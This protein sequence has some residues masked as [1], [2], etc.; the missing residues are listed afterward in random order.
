MIIATLLIHD[1]KKIISELIILDDASFKEVKYLTNCESKYSIEYRKILKEWEEK[2]RQL[3]QTQKKNR[4]ISYDMMVKL[5]NIIQGGCVGNV[6][7][8]N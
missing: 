3:E 2:Y 1:N 8:F 4:F 7:Y 6:E 5:E